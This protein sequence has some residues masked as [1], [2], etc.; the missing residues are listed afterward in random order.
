MILVSTATTFSVC[1]I[2]AGSSSWPLNEKTEFL[3]DG[4]TE[5]LIGTLSQ[6]PNMKVM[7]RSEPMFLA[8]DPRHRKAPMA[9]AMARTTA[10]AP[11][12]P[13]IAL[14]EGSQQCAG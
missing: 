1:R 11:T 10:T 14:G 6:L 9:A 2:F 4:L 8:D 13:G 5:D 3:S 7:A 12:Y